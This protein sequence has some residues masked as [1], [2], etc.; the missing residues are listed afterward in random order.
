MWTSRLHCFPPGSSRHWRRHPHRSLRL[1]PFLGIHAVAYGVIA[2]AAIAIAVYW[3]DGES[4]R[5]Q[6]T[7]ADGRIIR[8]NTQSGTVIACEGERQR[9]HIVRDGGA[10]LIFTADPD[11]PADMQLLKQVIGREAVEERYKKAM[12][13]DFIGGGS[14]I[15]EFV[16]QT[17]IA[18]ILA[19]ME[20][21]QRKERD[22]RED[23]KQGQD[24]Q[25]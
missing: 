17:N 1:S 21:L 9:K 11:N 3:Q 2:G 23:G 25:R 18:G 24:D 4:P 6:V 22:A 8:V 12:R 16:R 19:S 10:T 14:G 15:E 20:Q 7:A 13:G 5:Y